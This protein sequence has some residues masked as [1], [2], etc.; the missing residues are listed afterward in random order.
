MT[1][2]EPR[3]QVDL[4]NEISYAYRRISPHKALEYAER[5][6][7]LAEQIN[8]ESGLA[9]ALKN[10]GTY[11][12]NRNTHPDSTL[13]LF[14]RSLELALCLSEYYTVA[15][16]FNNIGLARQ[17]AGE[18]D[19]AI[20]HFLKGL[21]VF[22]QYAFSPEQMQLKY[23]LLGNL[24]S[25]YHQKEDYKKANYY[26]ESCINLSI[27]SGSRVTWAA[28]LDDLARV[29]V[30]LKQYDLAEEYFEE[31][32]SLQRE[33]SDY[34]SEIHTLT[35]YHELKLRFKDFKSAEKL[36]QESLN[37]AIE[38]DFPRLTYLANVYIGSLLLEQKKYEEA[39]T[40]FNTALAMSQMGFGKDVKRTLVYNLSKAYE[41]LGDSAKAFS[42]LQQWASQTDSLNRV[43]N[44][45][46]VAEIEGKYYAKQQEREIGRLGEDKRQ[47]Q[48][49][50]RS[51]T[52][53]VVILLV[54]LGFIYFLFRS[55]KKQSKLLSQ[56]NTEL[57]EVR[58][59]LN[60]SNYKLKEYIDS[61]LQL[62]NFAYMASHDL[63]SPL[64]NIIAFSER[65]LES[66]QIKL[67]ETENTLLQF[68][69]KNA[70]S[71][72][73]LIN[74]LLDYSRVN[75]EKLHPTRNYPREIIKEVLNDIIT[76]IKKNDAEIVLDMACNKAIAADKVKMK[77]VFQNLLL[78]AIK[79]C[80]DERSPLIRVS[81]RE[82]NMFWKFSV[83]DNG[84]GIEKEYTEQVFLIFRRLHNKDEYKGTGIGLAAVKR[85]VEQHN[86]EIWVESKVGKGST[87]HFTISKSLEKIT[88]EL[89]P[90]YA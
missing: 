59:Q 67:D 1:E 26:L 6:K 7:G 39:S 19:L 72:E 90:Q 3:F 11:H 76:D 65:L 23:R 87:F 24:G 52:S 31:A 63:R 44:A 88:K 74:S 20:Q 10:M 64:V 85:L 4:M 55:N 40:Y 14:K 35:A 82:E 27:E 89:K 15:S 13:Y 37:L 46:L 38:K 81:C 62:E 43:E 70:L 79:F 21:E 34:L 5:A 42:Y 41:G 18:V 71:M 9:I 17:Y 77:Q 8:Y 47:Q 22:E 49:M 84:I 29:K 53:F 48:V 16:C 50:I 28:F 25:I 60:R 32:L 12:L 73:T 54:L 78:N 83:A 69:H 30:Q 45:E 57:E 2:E 61:N 66:V 36:L 56:R 68:M 51:L 80:P 33:L 75:S 58:E 86:G